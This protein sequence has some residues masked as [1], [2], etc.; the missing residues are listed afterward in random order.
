MFARNLPCQKALIILLN[1][2]GK[3]IFNDACTLCDNLGEL[4]LSKEPIRSAINV[5]EML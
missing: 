1:L 4:R 5:R 3:V 2:L